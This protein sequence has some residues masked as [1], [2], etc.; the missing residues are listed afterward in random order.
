VIIIANN[1]G[2]LIRHL[3]LRH[4]SSEII[5]VYTQLEKR[6]LVKDVTLAAPKG[7]T[8]GHNGRAA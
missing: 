1:E 3:R 5:H 2:L 6:N 8:N 7:E 4:E